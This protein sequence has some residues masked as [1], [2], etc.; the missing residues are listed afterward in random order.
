LSIDDVQSTVAS[1]SVT[2]MVGVGYLFLDRELLARARH[3]VPRQD[4][5]GLRKVSSDP[6][7]GHFPEATLSNLFDTWY[8]EDVSWRSMIAC[9]R[10]SDSKSPLKLSCMHYFVVPELRAVAVG[11]V[12]ATE[13]V[14]E[15]RRIEGEFRNRALSFRVDASAR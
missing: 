10:Q 11:W 8:F 2:W 5:F 1:D 6:E 3:R 15:W 7:G 9:R 12:M 4:E 13:D 14:A